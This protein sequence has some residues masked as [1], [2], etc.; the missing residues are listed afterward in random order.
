MDD[1]FKK[2][3]EIYNPN[4]EFN[5]WMR[6]MENQLLKSKQLHDESKINS[7][8]CD[9]DIEPVEEENVCDHC[10]APCDGTY[11]SDDC[12]KYDLE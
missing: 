3:A 11:C 12:K 5:Q 2:F 1:L 4:S 8:L 9:A 10:K 6:G 7:M